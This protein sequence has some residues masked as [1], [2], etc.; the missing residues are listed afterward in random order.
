MN[1]T[2]TASVLDHGRAEFAFA[3]VQV[4]CD[5]SGVL[6]LPQ[7][8]TLVVSDLHLE[9]GAAFARRRLLLPPWDTAAT[10][11]RLAAAI[12]RYNP[13]RI[14]SLGDSFHDGGGAAAMPEMFRASLLALMAGREWIWIAGNHDPLHPADLP[15]ETM[16]AF[17]LAGLVFRHEPSPRPRPG[18]ISGHIHPAATVVLRGQA[19]RRACFVEDGVRLVMPAFGAFTG[20]ADISAPRTAGL[21]DWT[22]LN[23]YLL[24]KD[25]IYAMPGRMLARR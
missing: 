20:A 18:E 16:D 3:G 13:V 22:R 19:V 4:A 1:V 17:A 7:F 23:A 24:G 8:D 6:H 15:G 2:A 9:K 12:A 14:V 10:L 21:F 11:A 5:H 25:R